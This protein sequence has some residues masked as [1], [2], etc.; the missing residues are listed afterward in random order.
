MQEIDG[1][2]EYT[3]EELQ[4][5]NRILDYISQETLGQL[6]D[7]KISAVTGTGVK[8]VSYTS[9]QK[10]IGIE[11]EEYEQE[12]PEKMEMLGKD[13]TE[14]EYQVP[15]ET[16]EEATLQPEEPVAPEEIE[17]ITDLI[18][19]IGTK[20][21]G[22]ELIQEETFEEI[23]QTEIS[24][25]GKLPEEVF[26]TGEEDIAGTFE[27]EEKEKTEE[28]QP[29]E[30]LNLD[31]I[32]EELEKLAEEEPVPGK[33]SKKP[34]PAKP[35]ITEI[36]EEETLVEDDLLKEIESPAFAD[37]EIQQPQKIQPEPAG[38]K[39]TFDLD[40][41]DLSPAEEIEIK[42]AKPPVK[43]PA[44]DIG[45]QPEDKFPDIDFT[46]LE[47]SKV[48]TEEK[49]AAS[50]TAYE[51]IPDVD[52]SADLDKIQD[53]F[54]EE[55]PGEIALDTGFKPSAKPVE[56]EK[57]VTPEPKEQ[58]EEIELTDDELKRLNKVIQFFNPNLTKVIKD[59]ILNDLLPGNE[60]RELV[61]L[62]LSRVPEEEVK[63]FVE[64]KL[65]K[66]IDI[67]RPA[68]SRRVIT[69]RPEYTKEGKERQK[70][71]YKV[72]GLFAV[73]GVILFIIGVL[74]YQNVYIPVMAKK[75]IDEGV[76]LIKKTGVPVI[77]KQK[78]YK[79]AEE[80]FNNVNDNYIKDYFYGYHAY[81]R[82]YFQNKEYDY[83]I[84]K[85]NKAYNLN[86]MNIDTLN[87]L[88]F[89][90]SKL[91][92]VNFEKIKPELENYYFKKLKPLGP[93]DQQIDVA[94]DFY[95]KAISIDPKNI[96]ALFGIGNAYTNQGEF[97][98]AR[99][100]YENIL[101]VDKESAVGYSGLLNL[102]IERD[103]L[104][105]IIS[106]HSE[107]ENNK[108]LSEVPSP[109][110]AKLA[111]YYLSK[112]KTDEKNIRIDYGVQSAFIKDFNDN[113]YPAVKNVLNALSAKD[114]DYPPLFLQF[115]RL[116]KTE[117]NL[118]LMKRNL[119]TAIEK[120]NN[121]FAAHIL[122]AQYYY[123][124][125]DPVE[126]YKSSKNAL[127]AY[128]SP[129]EFTNEDFYYETEK[130]GTAY[131]IMGNIFYYADKTKFR[132]GDEFADENTQEKSDD[133]A[134]FSI[135]QDK[136][137][138]AISEN[139]KS[140]EVFYNLG[141][142][143]YLKS[144]FDKATMTWLNLYEEFTAEPELMF[145]LGNAFYHQNNLEAGKGEFLKVIS[146]FESKADSITQVVPERKE[147]IRIYQ[148][149]A[150]AYNNLGA[151]YQVQ[152]NESKCN[153]SY[154]KAIDYAKKLNK[155][156]EFAR[157]NMARAFKPSRENVLPIMDENI[158]VSIDN[159]REFK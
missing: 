109:L 154:W 39:D 116:S 122:L 57:A 20:E 61:N 141:R 114:M 126:A 6:P 17:D 101:A 140:A 128:L 135:A 21:E 98:K 105:E 33:E 94:I 155:E 19:E 132:F 37:L 81:A 48:K 117:D 7:N 15:E 24:K 91:P 43:P 111:S 143:Y 66:K 73:A 99:Q 100:Y 10:E 31:L 88:G 63:F 58:K 36:K 148:T 32:A 104:P 145:A 159:Y 79:I 53:M 56:K 16:E 156:N 107:L 8:E 150:S 35:E 147:H 23:P 113:P 131:A 119:Q 5:I 138:K 45:I 52:L 50:K 130:I 97:A 144:Q 54:E 134:N 87:N 12:Y 96:T 11:E 29:D 42:P 95:K 123:I 4:E 125:N 93:V 2:I 76:S 18:Q 70:R 72:T 71:L 41:S 90:Y 27:F 60:T 124:T 68:K 142:I 82:A 1:K 106:I 86:P 44:E 110:L 83:A 158:A 84:E 152:N 13:I 62:L 103:A 85:L 67:S 146:I 133:L 49:D 136:Y 3:S 59:V 108:K 47:E 30:E 118:N 28:I 89:F 80:I 129:P 115:A 34:A 153:I 75:Y 64:K 22:E 25:K 69:A 139:Y 14:E 77:Q 26:E 157:V 46:A 151:V 40:L 121:Y 120:D 102:Y 127:Q 137:E 149:L 65:N 74:L 38:K 51:K 78:D 92:A 112:K 9:P 55:K